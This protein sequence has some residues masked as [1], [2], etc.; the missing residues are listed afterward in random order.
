MPPF[1]FSTRKMVLMKLG[2]GGCRGT[3]SM[4]PFANMASTSMSTRGSFAPCEGVEKFT[5]GQESGGGDV[6][7]GR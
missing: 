2:G 5:P 3:S 7:G 1:F 6:K 4:A